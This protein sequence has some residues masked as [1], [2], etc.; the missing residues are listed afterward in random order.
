MIYTIIRR[1]ALIAAFAGTVTL[2]AAY[3]LDDVL[4]EWEEQ[5]QIQTVKTKELARLEVQA[6]ATAQAQQAQLTSLEIARQELDLT[7]KTQDVKRENERAEASLTHSLN[8]ESQLAWVWTTSQGVL[9]GLVG[10]VPVAVGGLIL[11]RVVVRKRQA[12]EDRRLI[13]VVASGTIPVSRDFLLNNPQAVFEWA[14]IRAEMEARAKLAS[15]EKVAMPSLTTYSP[16]MTYSPTNPQPVAQSAMPQLASTDQQAQGGQSA[17]IYETFQSLGLP[18]YVSLDAT[19]PQGS[20][21]GTPKAGHGWGD[22]TSRQGY[23]GSVGCG[24]CAHDVSSGI[25]VV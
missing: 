2:G 12:D 23:R 4:V 22:R 3:L 24:G 16:T 21:K 6:M 9:Y 15:A 5:A 14:T 25:C 10:I 11:W 8:R 19:G 1:S 18:V 20:D 13:D 7:L 17:E